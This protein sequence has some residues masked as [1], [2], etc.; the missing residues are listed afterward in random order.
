M[1]PLVLVVTIQ[2]LFSVSNVLARLQM[3]DQQWGKQL[4]TQPWIYLYFLMQFIGIILQLY[5]FTVFELGK[6]A[7]LLS[8]IAIVTSVVLGWL[9]L[10]EKLSPMT[11]VAI[12]M[13]I[14]AFIILAYSR[15]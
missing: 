11:Y 12:V 13:A 14:I 7:T 8:V 9:V 5:V 4:F 3:R 1:T 6:T 2:I 10:D 15:S